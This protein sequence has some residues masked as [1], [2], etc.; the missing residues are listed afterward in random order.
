MATLI[1]D[2]FTDTNGTALGSH[3]IAPTNTP[4][5]SWTVRNGTVQISSNRAVGTG[6]NPGGAGWV[7]TLDTGETDYR[8]S[9]TLNAGGTGTPQIIVRYSTADGSFYGVAIHDDAGMKIYR[10]DGSYTELYSEDVDVTN[11][12]DHTIT[13]EVV[14]T[15]L[16]ATR[17]G[18]ATTT[19]TMTINP[20][21]TLAGLRW[22]NVANQVDNLQVDEIGLSVSSPDAYQTFQRDTDDGTADIPISGTY[23]GTPT[24]IEARWDSGDWTTIDA[25]PS[26][27]AFSGELSSQSAGQGTLEVRFTNQTSITTSVANVGIGDVFLVAGQSNAEGRLT[28]SQSYSHATLVATM[29]RE[30]GSWAELADPTD[31][32]VATGSPWPLLA[33]SIMA[34]QSVPVAF[35]TA[36]DGATGLLAPNG[37]WVKGGTN[38]TATDTLVANSGVNGLRAILWHQG[39]KDADNGR[40]RELYAAALSQM[41]DDLQTALGFGAVKLVAAQ[42]AEVTNGATDD[43]IDAIRLAIADAWDDDADILPGPVLFDVNLSDAGGDGLHF[44]TDAEGQLLADRWWRALRAGIYDVG[45]T[46]VPARVASAVQTGDDTIEVTFTVDG[47]PLQMTDGDT[48]GWAVTDGNG[49]RTVTDAS[50]SGAV[51]TLTVDQDLSG[52]VTVSYGAGNDGIGSTLTDTDTGD[53]DMPPVPFV[54]LAASNASDPPTMTATA[55]YRQGDGVSAGAGYVQF[56]L[57]SQVQDAQRNLMIQPTSWREPLSSTGTIS[58]TVL[59]GRQYRITERVNDEQRTYTVTIPSTGTTVDLADLVQS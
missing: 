5:T 4:E 27:G 55:K 49:A 13:V 25:S 33:T 7:A 46:P 9:A 41:L 26:A 3:T 59:A 22:G 6:S 45:T 48:T 30:D 57:L 52:S 37:D 36:A 23:V 51:V 54:D 32:D 50:L 24:A 16:R 10:Y 8:I 39:E 56:E 18:G 11:S 19:V 20:S 12:Q 29:Y 42:L 40:S 17:T 44:K 43:A 35:I 34:D 47:S 28:N 15:T 53:A 31:S 1:L 14:G 58:T 38:F 2:Q 21:S